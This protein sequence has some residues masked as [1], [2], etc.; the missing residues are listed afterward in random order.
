MCTTLGE[1]RDRAHAGAR[2]DGVSARPDVFEGDS[3]LFV[4]RSFHCSA[5]GLIK[6][7]RC[8]S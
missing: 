3:E 6:N 5:F 4:P 1:E 8:C 7:L 2:M